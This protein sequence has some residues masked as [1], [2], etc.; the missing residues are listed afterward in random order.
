MA[1]LKTIQVRT[2]YAPWLS[3]TTLGLIRERNIQQKKASEMNDQGEWKKFKDIRNKI[4]N[5]MK[6]EE[7]CWK[8]SKLE[9][10]GDNSSKV[11]RNVKGILQW[12]SAGSPNQLFYKG[13]LL[14][15]PQELAEAQNN[16]FLEKIKEI[17]NN[18]PP[19]VI[20]PLHHLKKLMHGRNCS[21]TLSKVHPDEIETIINGLSNSTS[22]GLDYID[23]YIILLIKN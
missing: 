6:H 3:K 17:R 2:K 15:K 8:K 22:F 7:K 10:C 14:S 1:P 18:L 20:D 4:N 11:W 12:R 21:F 23:T 16:Y 5:R 9:E 13:K 19:A